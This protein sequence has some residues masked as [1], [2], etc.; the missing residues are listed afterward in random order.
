MSSPVAELRQTWW[1]EATH[2]HYLTISVHREFTH[3]LH[4]S[5][6]KELTHKAAIKMLARAAVSSVARLGNDLL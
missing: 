5:S 4:G 1:L 6:G 3:G 2:I